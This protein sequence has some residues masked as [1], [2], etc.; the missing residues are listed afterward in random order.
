[1]AIDI[2]LK[3]GSTTQDARLDRLVHFDERSRAYRAVT[4]LEEHPLRSYTWRVNGWLDQRNEGACVGFAWSHELIARPAEIPMTDQRAREV[5]FRAQQID[6]WAGG[7][8]PGASPFYEG[9]S[10][11]AGAKAVMEL[12]T[13]KGKPVM[14]S[15]R[16]IFGLEDGVR[17]VGYRG[18]ITLGINWKYGMF[19]TDAD[20]YIHNTG[21]V[22]G[23]HAILWHAV[24]CVFSGSGKTFTDLDLERS[25]AVL[26]NSWGRTSWGVEGRAKISLRD[27]GAL[28]AEDGEGCLAVKRNR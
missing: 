18:P 26:H 25:Y 17:V 5:Y 4:G 3:D 11:L 28:L 10:V 27:L 23:G 21:A 22:V 14:E 19:E 15:Y 16:W 2:V 13:A 7:A 1:M 9:T 12:T 24:K 20:G 8:Y 6:Q